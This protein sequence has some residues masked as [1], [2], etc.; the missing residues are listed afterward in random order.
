MHTHYT[1]NYE[2]PLP[3]TFH[4][5]MESWSEPVR[6]HGSPVASCSVAEQSQNGIWLKNWLGKKVHSDITKLSQCQLYY[7]NKEPAIVLCML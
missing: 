3:N 2:T 7:L 1:F 4:S 6:G 5:L